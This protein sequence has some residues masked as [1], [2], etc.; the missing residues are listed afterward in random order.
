M[1]SIQQEAQLRQQSMEGG[2]FIGH[3]SD[4]YCMAEMAHM[5]RSEMSMARSGIDKSWM[6]G[7]MYASE[8]ARGGSYGHS[9]LHDIPSSYRAGTRV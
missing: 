7:G 4:A 3:D 2:A 9:H 6:G 1:N 8:G 5:R